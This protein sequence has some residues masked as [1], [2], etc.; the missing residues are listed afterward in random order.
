MTV[1]EVARG[2]R[3]WWRGV[4]GEDAYDRFVDHQQRRHPSAPIPTKRDFWREKYADQERNP[5]SRCC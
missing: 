3:W 2:V 1:A 4:V 5:R